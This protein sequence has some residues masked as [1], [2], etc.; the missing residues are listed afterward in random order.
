MPIVSDYSTTQSF[1]ETRA[2]FSG[3]PVSALKVF[4]LIFSVYSPTFNPYASVTVFTAIP[5]RISSVAAIGVD[6][7]PMYNSN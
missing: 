5:G 1:A 3:V 4:T 2:L 6:S 7:S